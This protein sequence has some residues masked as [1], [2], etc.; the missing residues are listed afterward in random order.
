[1]NSPSGQYTPH[2]E[3][4]TAFW[5]R[6]AD[7]GTTAKAG[8]IALAV[9]VL[10]LLP[11]MHFEMKNQEKSFAAALTA[12]EG[13]D[14]RELPPQR[15]SQLLKRDH[16]YTWTAQ[17]WLRD[18]A[19][20]AYTPWQLTATVDKAQDF[21]LLDSRLEPILPAEDQSGSGNGVAVFRAVQLKL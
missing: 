5:E 4:R 19:G 17:V 15:G 16:L 13:R 9:A 2:P 14:V 7:W 18:G 11:W 3:G 12:L 20:E 6:C 1:M 8:F 21:A 10:V